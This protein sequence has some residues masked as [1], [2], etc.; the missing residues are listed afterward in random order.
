MES[1]II[2]KHC[3]PTFH[4][5]LCLQGDI[6]AAALLLHYIL[7]LD[8]C[9]GVIV[10]GFTLLNGVYSNSS[11]DIAFCGLTF[12]FRAY[13]SNCCPLTLYSRS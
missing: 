11:F 13:S 5:R 1:V 9:S 3:F 6:V 7:K 10:A 12:A 8:F 2:A 4:A